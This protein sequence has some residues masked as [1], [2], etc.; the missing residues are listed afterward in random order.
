M[1][2]SVPR[3]G[4]SG[5]PAVASV[6]VVG[7]EP[8]AQQQD[9]ALAQNREPEVERKLQ[10]RAEQGDAQEARAQPGDTMDDAA[11]QRLLTPSCWNFNGAAASAATISERAISTSC[12]RAVTRQIARYRSH[13][14]SAW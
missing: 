9:D 8:L 13:M 3:F 11:L 14:K 1:V 6:H 7:V 4:V 2:T 10:H 12:W 5:A